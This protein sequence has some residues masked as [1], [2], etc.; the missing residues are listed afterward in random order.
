MRQ[1]RE[2]IHSGALEILA[3][4][5]G[6]RAVGAAMVAYRLNISA[7]S[8]FASVEDL[9]VEPESRRQGVGCELLRL[10]DERCSIRGISYVEV[11]V[12]EPDAESFYAAC[13]YQ[14]EAEV[15]VMSRSRPLR[16]EQ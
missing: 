10:A 5:T 2:G 3:A 1:L 14:W 9:Y 11:Q 13:G 4:Y 8:Y 16:G 15:E 12:E 7:G 6:E